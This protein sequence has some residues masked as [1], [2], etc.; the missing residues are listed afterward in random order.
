M[1]HKWF[2]FWNR[3]IKCC[4]FKLKNH[5]FLYLYNPLVKSVYT[6]VFPETHST[7]PKWLL[8]LSL[9][10]VPKKTPVDFFF[11]WMTF[12]TSVSRLILVF[13]FLVRDPKLHPFSWTLLLMFILLVDSEF[14]Y[15]FRVDLDNPLRC[16]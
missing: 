12:A 10:I 16:R 14:D 9:I 5:K 8:R 1:E 2:I 7:K 3:F 13:L 6:K 15:G 11:S 4:F